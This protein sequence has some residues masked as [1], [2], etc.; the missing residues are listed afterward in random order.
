MGQHDHSRRLST[1]PGPRS[2][3]A[4]AMVLR[5]YRKRFGANGRG[6]LCAS[7]G[8]VNFNNELNID[9]NMMIFGKSLPTGNKVS[10][11]RISAG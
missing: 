8:A 11:K 7:Q 1:G 4:P 10:S 3:E 6:F 9:G 5:E 2:Q